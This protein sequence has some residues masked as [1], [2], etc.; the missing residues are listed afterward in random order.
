[1]SGLEEK[2]AALTERVNHL[3]GHQ[4]AQDRRLAAIEEG[5][6]KILKFVDEC[7]GGRKA[8]LLLKVSGGLAAIAGV[9]WAWLQGGGG[10]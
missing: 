7:S 5:Q 9:L 8:L 10:K 2:V 6:R 3:C 4:V 1:M